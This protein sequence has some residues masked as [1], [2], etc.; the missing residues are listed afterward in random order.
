MKKFSLFSFILDSCNLN[1]NWIGISIS[2]IF[3]PPPFLATISNYTWKK[4]KPVKKKVSVRS[5]VTAIIL[6]IQIDERLFHSRLSMEKAALMVK[7]NVEIHFVTTLV[8]IRT[9][10]RRLFFSKFLCFQP[11]RRRKYEYKVV[12]LE[13]AD[14]HEKAQENFFVVHHFFQS[15]R[16]LSAILEGSSRVTL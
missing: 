6:L 12:E 1:F 10:A 8:V 13:K 16:R 4:C 9:Q 15:W 5:V 11:V 2:K 3:P 14:E 7:T